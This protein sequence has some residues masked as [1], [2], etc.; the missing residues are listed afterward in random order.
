MGWEHIVDGRV[1]FMRRAKAY[2]YSCQKTFWAEA[3]TSELDPEIRVA[4]EEELRV[5]VR[6]RAITDGCSHRIT[7]RLV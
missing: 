3:R 6:E 5:A 2:C 4:E 7:V 1:Y